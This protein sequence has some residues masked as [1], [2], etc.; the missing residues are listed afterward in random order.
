MR[1][2]EGSCGNHL[3][4]HFQVHLRKSNRLTFH[5]YRARSSKGERGYHTSHDYELCLETLDHNMLRAN[6]CQPITTLEDCEAQLGEYHIMIL[7]SCS[8]GSRHADQR[9]IIKETNQEMT[10]IQFCCSAFKL[11]HNS[12]LSITWFCIHSRT[13]G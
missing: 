2:K 10:Y 9:A 7:L 11:A 6:Q 3:H 5:L 13:D 4:F 12:Q 8:L 1:H